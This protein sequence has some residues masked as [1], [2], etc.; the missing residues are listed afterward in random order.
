MREIDKDYILA[1][2]KL[3]TES[4]C[5]ILLDKHKSG[6][7]FIK[8][9]SIL[10]HG[11]VAYLWYGGFNLFEYDKVDIC[12]KCEHDSNDR[13]KTCF[14]PDHL[15]LGNNSTNMLDA[16]KN[17]THIN[18]RETHCPK[19]HLYNEYNKVWGKIRG[20]RCGICRIQKRI[21][22]REKE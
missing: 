20:R 1:L 6:T 13:S 7:I 14:N 22:E 11:I 4:G 16:S 3:I 19:G 18:A 2:P 21:R 15:Y 17:K 9:K 8:S 12:H 5:W 10:I